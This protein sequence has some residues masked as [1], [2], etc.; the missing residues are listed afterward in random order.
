[1]K[2]AHIETPTNHK[3]GF[4]FTL[5]FTLLSIYFF[6]NAL[7]TYSIFTLSVSVCLLLITILNA[8]LL[9]PF[10]KI[11]MGLGLLLSIVASPI[12]MGVIF[13]GLFTPISFFM[14]A[15]ARDELSIKFA[16]RNSF[17]KYY[18]NGAERDYSFKYQF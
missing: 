7:I 4:F 11:W 14:K 17:W 10:N 5:V 2:L 8:K 12:L 9:Q 16:D 18:N 1:M 3:F 13:F 15:I 6:F